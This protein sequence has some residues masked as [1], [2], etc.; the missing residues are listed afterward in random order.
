[1]R[2]QSSVRNR[3]RSQSAAMIK[4]SILYPNKIISKGYAANIMPANYGTSLTKPQLDA[5]V[6]YVNDAVNG[7]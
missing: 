3:F 5:L 4:A 6:K 2:A 1:M 7:K